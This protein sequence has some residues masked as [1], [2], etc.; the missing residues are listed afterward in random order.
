MREFFVE[1]PIREDK[2]PGWQLKSDNETAPVSVGKVRGAGTVNDWND[3][4]PLYDIQVGDEITKVNNVQ[5]HGNTK[6][7][8]ARFNIQMEAARKGNGKQSVTLL[9]R[10]PWPS[11]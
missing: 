8:M 5:W 10:R 7:F 9:V 3:Q 1:L 2:A 6:Q 11:S 4:N